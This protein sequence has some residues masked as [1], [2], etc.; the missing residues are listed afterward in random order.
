MSEDETTTPQPDAP[1]SPPPEGP[2]PVTPDPGKP[3]THGIEYSPDTK[4]L[5]LDDSERR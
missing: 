2:G 5:S 1:S 4:P 3:Q